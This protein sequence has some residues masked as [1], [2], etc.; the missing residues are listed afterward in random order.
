MTIVITFSA[1]PPEAEFFT[2]R[3]NSGLVLETITTGYAAMKREPTVLAM[4]IADATE[5]PAVVAAA[6]QPCCGQH[7]DDRQH[8]H[9][10]RDGVTA[11]HGQRPDEGGE[12]ALKAAVQLTLPIAIGITWL[13]HPL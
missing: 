11:R 1:Y 4:A 6:H 13:D 2:V 8:R 5:H 3:L 10:A 9:R 12:N 7:R